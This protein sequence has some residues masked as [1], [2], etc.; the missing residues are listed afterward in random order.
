MHIVVD[1]HMLGEQEGGNETYIAGLL[2]GFES[3]L[4]SDHTQITALHSP[5]YTSPRK[6]HRSIRSVALCSKSDFRRLFW[7]IPSI[8]RRLQA[9]LLHVTYNAP[10]GSVCPFV[11]TVHDVI[12]RLYPEYFSPRVRVLLSTLMPLSMW[13][14]AV[15]LTVSE[16]SKQDITRYYP[17]ARDK[18][19][20][21]P[22]A[23][24]PVATAK[25]GFWYRLTVRMR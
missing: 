23:A 9:D 22:E 7:E 16:A 8:C 25:P 20:V 2:E 5:S 21:I 18:I 11:V 24:G 1:A 4:P 15:V 12:F 13:R 6:Q 19:M 10:I 3:A 14:A 17:F